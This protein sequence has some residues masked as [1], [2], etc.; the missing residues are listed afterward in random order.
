MRFSERTRIAKTN[1]SSIERS[2]CLFKTRIICAIFLYYWTQCIDG[3]SLLLQ[4]YVPKG[5]DA[6]N[7]AILSFSLL[8]NVNPVK[9]SACAVARK[10]ETDCFCRNLPICSDPVVE[11]QEIW[12]NHVNDL[13]QKIWILTE[14]I[15]NNIEHAVKTIYEE[16]RKSPMSKF[17]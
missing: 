9:C 2:F 10:I 8:P 12:Q 13:S 15:F 16:L 3:F 1:L 7:E 17:Y 11:F 6:K 4:R 14:G 5:D